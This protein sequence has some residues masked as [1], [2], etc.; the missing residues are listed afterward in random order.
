MQ[1]IIRLYDAG[2]LYPG[3]SKKRNACQKGNRCGSKTLY[4]RKYIEGLSEETQSGGDGCVSD[5]I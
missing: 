2:Q 1:A 4:K 5:R 3:Q